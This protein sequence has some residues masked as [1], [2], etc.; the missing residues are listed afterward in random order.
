MQIRS[1]LCSFWTRRLSSALKKV[2]SRLYLVQKIKDEFGYL[3]QTSQN[4]KEAEPRIHQ[5][6]M[7]RGYERI[8]ETIRSTISLTSTFKI[9]GDSYHPTNLSSFLITLAF[10]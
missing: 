7:V 1:Q 8:T 4:N 5:Y 10:A 9:D 6:E 3:D 2:K